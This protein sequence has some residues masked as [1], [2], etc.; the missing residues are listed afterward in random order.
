MLRA[1]H[2]LDNRLIDGGK[3]SALRTGRTLL[4]RNIIIL[5]S[6]VLISVRGC[7]YYFTVSRILGFHGGD[8]KE[9]RLLGCGAV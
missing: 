9:C 4:P 8:Y 6:L 7:V 5:I 2:C 1:P 3:V